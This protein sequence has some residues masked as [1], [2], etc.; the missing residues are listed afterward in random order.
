MKEE[1]SIGRLAALDERGRRSLCIVSTLKRK[2]C[3]GALAPTV[4]GF[5]ATLMAAFPSHAHRVHAAHAAHAAHASFVGGVF[6]IAAR[7]A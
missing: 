1:L 4:G 7:P 5:S 3:R 6:L 2:F